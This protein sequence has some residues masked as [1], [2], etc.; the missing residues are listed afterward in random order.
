[1]M[2][3]YVSENAKGEFKEDI[4]F[5]YDQ[6]GSFSK[7]HII[8]HLDGKLEPYIIVSRFTEDMCGG[9]TKDRYLEDVFEALIGAIYLDFNNHQINIYNSFFAG[10]G[11]Q[12]AQRFIL[13]FQ[14]SN[15]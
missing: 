10:T 5:W 13:N 15:F 4:P 8:Q 1:M 11:Y 6:I 2:F 12:V 7:N 14:V 9:R 3:Y